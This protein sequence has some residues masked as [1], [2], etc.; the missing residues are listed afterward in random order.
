MAG[1]RTS[2]NTCRARSSQALYAAPRCPSLAP[3]SFRSFP[4]HSS[5]RSVSA[6]TPVSP[7]QVWGAAPLASNFCCGSIARRW[8]TG[9]P[10]SRAF[11]RPAVR[12]SWRSLSPSPASAFCVRVPNAR[13]NISTTGTKVKPRS[14]MM[15]SSSV[16][17]LTQYLK[18][19]DVH[20]SCKAAKHSMA[21]GRYYL[22]P[23]ER[24]SG[25]S[26][27]YSRAC[28]NPPASCKVLANGSTIGRLL[29]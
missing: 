12:D 26:D 29:V 22:P 15:E 4:H 14:G 27:A 28:Y 10:S 5:T 25:C 3:Q 6:L 17:E 16:N 20:F 1:P 24:L 21:P 7:P 23:D 9:E 18:I 8:R 2:K 11:W 13:F 19:W